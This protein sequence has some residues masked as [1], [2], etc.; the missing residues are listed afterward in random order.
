MN[1]DNYTIKAQEVIQKATEFA[2]SNQQQ[3][4]ETGHFLKGILQSDE[5]VVGFL[6]KKLNINQT[7]LKDRLEEIVQEYPKVSGQQPYLSNESHAALQS[8]GSY[9]KIFH[10]EF[11]AVEHI[12]LGVLKGKDKTAGLLRDSGFNEKDLIAAIQ[13][14]RGGESVKDPNAEAKYRSLERYSKNLNELAKAGKID[15]VIGRDEEIRRVL[16]ILSR[17]TKNNPILLG[18]PGVGENGDCG[19]YGATDRRW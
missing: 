15:P 7:H 17:R 8:A 12:L 5:N 1:F 14:L 13:E 9:L 18:E 6:M 10:D 19:R 3:A 4:V 16:Q 2:L 11:I